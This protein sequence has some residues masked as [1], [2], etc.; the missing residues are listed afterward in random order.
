[1]NNL[2]TGAAWIGHAAKLVSQSRKGAKSQCEKSQ[3]SRPAALVARAES[4][5]QRNRRTV[6]LL[7]SIAGIKPG[8]LS[9][10][11]DKQQEGK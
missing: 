10:F 5:S 11:H 7:D 1:M 3:G 9:P 4:W 2:M 6:A 8:H